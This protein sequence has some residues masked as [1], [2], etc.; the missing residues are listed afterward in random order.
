MSI[1][2]TLGKTL[3]HLWDGVEQPSDNKDAFIC[4]AIK[5]AHGLRICSNDEKV[6]RAIEFLETYGMQLDGSWFQRESDF[7]LS[8]RA[9]RIVRQ[10]RRRVFLTVAHRHAARLGI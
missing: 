4:L 5:K 8:T 10:A 7:G 9:T 6:R 1:A 2:K 3:E